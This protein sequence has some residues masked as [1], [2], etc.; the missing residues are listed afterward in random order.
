MY[1]A[2]IILTVS[3]ELLR[4]GSF[5]VAPPVAGFILVYVQCASMIRRK[6]KMVMVVMFKLVL[7]ELL[8]LPPWYRA[9][10]L[11][12]T[13]GAISY[14]SYYPSLRDKRFCGCTNAY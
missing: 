7:N 8:L 14:L 2:V 4:R 13:V 11:V 10:T 5:V 9:A 12:T 3:T 6:L 1:T